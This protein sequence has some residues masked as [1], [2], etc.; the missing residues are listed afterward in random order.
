MEDIPIT[1]MTITVAHNGLKHEIVLDG[2]V[3][4]D[5]F[6]VACKVL[7]MALLYHFDD[8]E[9]DCIYEKYNKMLTNKIIKEKNNG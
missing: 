5:G 6:L 1:D 4:K 2:D 7:A 9:C 8:E 3:T